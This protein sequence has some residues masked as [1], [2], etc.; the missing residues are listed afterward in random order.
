VVFNL[1]GFQR[2]KKQKSA[3]KKFSR[4]KEEERGPFF[5]FEQTEGSSGCF[6]F[7]IELNK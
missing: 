1:I 6:L 3:G 7:E 2:P 4:S 5:T